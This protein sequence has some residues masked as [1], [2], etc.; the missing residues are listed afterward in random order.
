MTSDE[1]AAGPC[2][3]LEPGDAIDVFYKGSL[4]HRGTVL[5]AAPGGGPVWMLDTLTGDRRV[6]NLTELEI[7]RLAPRYR[8]VRVGG[9][10]RW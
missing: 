6:L 9:A 7:V 3:A 1:W 2:R 5:G 10:S 4:V 8:E